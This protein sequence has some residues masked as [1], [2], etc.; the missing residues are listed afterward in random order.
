MQKKQRI[1]KEYEVR[2]N[3]LLDTAWELFVQDGYEKV[4]V[5]TIIEKVGVAKGT[6]YHYF[7]S[8]EELLQVLVTRHTEEHMAEWR[9]IVEDQKLSGLEKLNTVLCA[10]K[11]V[12]IEHKNIALAFIRH[13]F[14]EE[15]FLLRYRY[16]EELADAGAEILYQVVEQGVREGDFNTPYPREAIRLVM[17][18]GKTILED[19]VDLILLIE[20]KP[21]NREKLLRL[22]DVYRD[23]MERILGAPKDSIRFFDRE[24]LEA[25]FPQEDQ[26]GMGTDPAAGNKADG[27]K[28]PAERL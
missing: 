23:A 2:K 25:M 10:S 7:E 20:E 4:S 3:E 12:K 16:N 1:T 17:K 11:E 6:F 27:A 5:N 13:F 18:L 8:K 15:N 22:Y 26:D 9:K 28:Q 14:R 19:M 21:E 24:F